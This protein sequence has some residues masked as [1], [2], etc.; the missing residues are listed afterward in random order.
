[1]T[2]PSGLY[3]HIPFC[4]GKCAYCD[5]YSVAD[6]R[7]ENGFV[8]ALIKEIKQWGASF[9]SPIDTVYFGGGTPSLLAHRLPEIMAAVN[10]AFCVTENAEITMEINPGDN[11]EEVLRFALKS[12]VNRLSVGVQ[13]GI[14]SELKALERRH[15][16]A[17]ADETVFN[18]RSLGFKNISLDL[19]I[20]L[21]SSSRETLNKNLEYITSLEPEHISAYILK[22]E[23]NTAFWN[24]KDSLDLPNDDQTAEQYLQMCDFLKAGGYNHYEISNFSKEGF[25]SRHN[26]KYWRCEEY[27]GLGPAAHSFIKGKRFYYNRSLSEFI[28]GTKPIADGEGGSLEEKIMLALR[29]NTGIDLKYINPTPKIG[30]LEKGGFLKREN[31]RISLTDRGMLLSNSIINEILECII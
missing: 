26:L 7:N 22:I 28:N 27:L 30:L 21:P 23:P 14:N 19:M 20:G 10:S 9:G 12:G 18:A 29:L 2:K 24:R 31:S 16:A 15:T 6:R 8:N 5:F 25:E 13:S 17:E 1:M 3:I 4:V 11:S